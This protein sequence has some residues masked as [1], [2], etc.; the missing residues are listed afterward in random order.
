MF[1][2][3]IQRVRHVQ[4]DGDSSFIAIG[5][6][7]TKLQSICISNGD[8]AVR[9][10]LNAFD[11]ESHQSPQ[12]SAASCFNMLEK[13]ESLTS[14]CLT[15]CRFRDS[16]SSFLFQ[17]ARLPHSIQTLDLSN[18]AFGNDIALIPPLFNL[19]QLS[20]L[21]LASNSIGRA[22]AQMPALPVNLRVL[23]LSGNRLDGHL[24]RMSPLPFKLE[25]LCLFDNLI[26]E[27]DLSFEL[28]PTLTSLCL[29]SNPIGRAIQQFKFPQSLTNLELE[30][31]N[32][33]RTQVE[34]MGMVFPPNLLS[35]RF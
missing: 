26:G 25:T 1:Q 13:C 20:T 10:P 2:E 21:C 15:Q 29:S 8:C 14:L 23:C 4:L 9:T 28:P 18:C 3:P 31:C 22:A 27:D 24:C 17:H 5:N 7:M 11:N 6:C 16:A 33:G 32:L 30:R 35:L 12:W 34:L 19:S